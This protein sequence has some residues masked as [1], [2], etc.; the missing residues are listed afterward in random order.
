MSDNN[1]GN[2]IL[3]QTGDN[4]GGQ[5]QPTMILG[6]FRDTEA[7]AHAYTDL[8]KQFSSRVKVPNFSTDSEESVEK[9]YS[10]VRPADK[11]VYDFSGVEDED[12]L[13]DIAYKN[14]LNV[15][16]AKSI[17]DFLSGKKL[18][19]ANNYSQEG[20]N[21][22]AT[23]TFGDRAA[24]VSDKAVKVLSATFDE[25]KIKEINALDNRAVIALYSVIDKLYKVEEG[26][27]IPPS[28][29]PIGTANKEKPNYA[30]FNKEYAELKTKP[31]SMAQV[32]A[33]KKKYNIN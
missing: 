5:Q 7:L 13:R 30:E 3:P 2:D 18:V 6:K 33:L 32:E 22:L 4:T 31:H 27:I 1:E 26:K 23:E 11:S 20:A 9:F 28:G 12:A 10:K 14:G 24:E 25:D 17:K 15:L 16:Q 29:S 19:D 8:E 21:K